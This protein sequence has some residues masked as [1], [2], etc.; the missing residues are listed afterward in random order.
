MVEKT[1]GRLDIKSIGLRN[2]SRVGTSFYVDKKV[3]F[4]T[5]LD[6]WE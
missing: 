6:R 4:M 2:K 1:G 5:R 3:W